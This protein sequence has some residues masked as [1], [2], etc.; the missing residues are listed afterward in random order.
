MEIVDKENQRDDSGSEKY[1]V[2]IKQTAK[3]LY[4]LGSLRIN[5]D[6]INEMENSTNKS[7]L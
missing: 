4:Y 3:G 5:A 2:V 6:S 1:S 7:Y